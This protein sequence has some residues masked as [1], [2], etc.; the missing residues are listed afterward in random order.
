[1]RPIIK[2]AL[3]WGLVYLLLALVPLLLALLRPPAD[4]RGFL[5]EFG[6]LL[7]LLALGVFAMQ[8]VASGRHRWFAGSLGFDNV[9]QFHR[10]MGLF[11]LLLVVA[12]PATLIIAEPRYF[13]YLD[14]RQDT[15]R[16]L[17]L[18]TLLV[19]TVILIGSSLW[20]RALGLSYEW[21]RIVHG[22]LAAFIVL[23][24]I[25]H[26]LMVG[27]YTAGAVTIALLLAALAIP[28]GLLLDS[29]LLRPLRMRRRGWTVVDN[30]PMRG[31]ATTLTLEADDGRG[32]PF[33]PGQ[34]IWVTIGDTPFSLQ[35]HPFSLVTPPT[36]GHRIAFTA[37]RLGDFT[38]SLPEVTPGTRAWVEGPYG[39]FVPDTANTS[40]AVLIAGGI[41]ITPIISILRTFNETG[42]KIP[43]WLIYANQRWEETTFREELERHSRSLALEV[44]H[45]L[46][47]PHDGW[48]GDTGYVD[49]ALLARRLPADD[50][51][52]EYFIC[53]PDPL[54]DAA[55]MGL[56]RQG[57]SP[58][59]IFSD[60]FDLV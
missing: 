57:V 22:G 2:R 3:A 41:G 54:M 25:G 26:A 21:W 60:R 42:I 44:V 10:Q 34:F 40:G 55:E 46:A 24:G 37:K 4:M 11:A 14:P 53:G 31:D 51:Q 39:A 38:N 18:L 35:Q 45:V 15:L 28:L 13:E 12:H 9:L 58:A 36:Q 20:R 43:L 49:G 50:G 17:A 1:M 19:A 32:M 7:G 8:M 6:A 30:R 23:G 33:Q 56:I 48:T 5:V 59:R 29:R 16:A 27:R 47:Q 52:R